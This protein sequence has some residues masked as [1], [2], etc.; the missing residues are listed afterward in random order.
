[1]RNTPI[2]IAAQ[3]THPL[4]QR[5]CRSCYHQPPHFHQRARFTGKSLI[6]APISYKNIDRIASIMQSWNELGYN[7]GAVSKLLPAKTTQF[8][9]NDMN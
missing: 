1:M 9:Q 7:V 3:R 6:T 8:S 4:H 5:A 2:T